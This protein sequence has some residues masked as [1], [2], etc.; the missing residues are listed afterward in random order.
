[1]GPDAPIPANLLTR[2]SINQ[3]PPICQ[4]TNLLTLANLLIHQSIYTSPMT[5]SKT[6]ILVGKI[7]FVD[8]SNHFNTFT[9]SHVHHYINYPRHA[10]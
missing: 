2:Q 6:S 1:M 10:L 9:L 3:H 4:F 7:H 5:L 8:N